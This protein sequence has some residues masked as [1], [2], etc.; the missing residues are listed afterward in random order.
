MSYR[1]YFHFTP[2]SEWYIPMQEEKIR[3]IFHSFGQECLC[4]LS[5][6]F[7]LAFSF[8]SSLVSSSSFVLDW[9]CLLRRLKLYSGVVIIMILVMTVRIIHP[10]T[11]WWHFQW[12]QV[13]PTARIKSPI[14]KL[15]LHLKWLPARNI[16]V[17]VACLFVFDLGMLLVDCR[18]RVGSKSARWKCT[19]PIWINTIH[20]YN[21]TA[22]EIQVEKHKPPTPLFPFDL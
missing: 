19:F 8:L 18:L 16:I 2:A 6:L 20:V 5:L 10:A 11:L 13:R 7:C 15:Q 14:C 1:T 9:K 4:R 12:M 21:T 17:K 3:S 22:K